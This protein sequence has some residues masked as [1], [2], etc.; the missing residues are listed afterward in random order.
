MTIIDMH[1]DDLLDR[2]LSGTLS[3]SEQR[4]LTEHLVQCATCRLERQLRDD[5][6]HELVTARAP[7]VLQTFVSGALRA[8]LPADGTT[9]LGMQV[10]VAQESP[11]VAA[12][13]RSS[14]RRAAFL[15]V[16]FVIASAVAAAQMGLIEQVAGFARSEPAKTD[17][18]LPRATAAAHEPVGNELAVNEA[19]PPAE[20]HALNDTHGDR[21]VR[22]P[23]VREVAPAQVEDES[24]PPRAREAKKERSA[25]ARK[26]RASERQRRARHADTVAEAPAHSA[27]EVTRSAA[28]VSTLELPPNDTNARAV[29]PSVRARKSLERSRSEVE[30]PSLLETSSYAPKVL[31][32]EAANRVDDDGEPAVASAPSL[33]HHA[34]SARRE[35]LSSEALHAYERLRA[36]FPNSAEARLSLVLGA[37]MHLDSGRLGDA[38]DGFDRYIA[39]RDRSLREQALAGRA[40]ALGRLGRTREELAAWQSLLLDYPDSSYAALASQRLEQ[41]QR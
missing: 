8:A 37:R 24:P 4:R 7:D 19:P 34:N 27:A 9:P 3:P 1:P 13:R 32:P 18:P 36:E 38:V 11:A 26:A 14:R 39:T 10:P 5:F 16:A 15:G 20:H 22:A 28:E 17:E 30:S 31:H 23:S 6:S 40:I 21:A 12:P 33:F 41:V 25:R 2:E 29:A 35:G